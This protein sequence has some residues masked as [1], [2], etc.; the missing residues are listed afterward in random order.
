L[1][2]P[3][4]SAYNEKERRSFRARGKGNGMSKTKKLEVFSDYI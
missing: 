1:E 2:N 3:G 4:E